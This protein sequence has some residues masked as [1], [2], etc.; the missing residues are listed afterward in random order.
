MSAVR[1]VGRPASP[2][3]ARGPVVV[4]RAAADRSRSAGSPNRKPKIKEAT[5]AAGSVQ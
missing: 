1:L 5:P 3:F 4:L 2:G